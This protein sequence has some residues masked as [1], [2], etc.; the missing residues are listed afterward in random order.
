M[1]A[2]SDSSEK[3]T[4]T[5]F[6][7]TASRMKGHINKHDLAVSEKGPLAVF[8]LPQRHSP[9]QMLLQRKSLDSMIK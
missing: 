4:A 5:R 8:H 1:K 3:E 6:N 9:A 7:T 2:A